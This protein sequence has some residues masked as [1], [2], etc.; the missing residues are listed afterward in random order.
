MLNVGLII[1]RVLLLL[2]YSKVNGSEDPETIAIEKI[3]C[4]THRAQKKGTGHT[5][6]GDT[7]KHHGQSGGRGSDGKCGQEPLLWFPQG[8]QGKQIG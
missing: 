4:Y 3:V 8:R 7:G 1:T 5:M 2:R 6:V